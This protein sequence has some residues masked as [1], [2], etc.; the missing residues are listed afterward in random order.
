MKADKKTLRLGL[1]EIRDQANR[2]LRLLDT[3]EADRVP[4]IVDE[5]ETE[6]LEVIADLEGHGPE[7]GES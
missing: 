2:C 4:G 7:D 1:T 5:M 6:V 3:E